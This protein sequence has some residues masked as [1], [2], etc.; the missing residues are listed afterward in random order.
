[1]LAARRLPDDHETTTGGN[2]SDKKK[3]VQD[4]TGAKYTADGSA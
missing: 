2:K 1:M 4:G 3:P